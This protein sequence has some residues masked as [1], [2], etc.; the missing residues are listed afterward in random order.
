MQ[1]AW[2]RSGGGQPP[3]CWGEVAT[4]APGKPT[5][6]N[7]TFFHRVRINRRHARIGQG[8][9]PIST[10]MGWASE[11]TSPFRF[12]AEQLTRLELRPP[13]VSFHFGLPE[14]TAVG[15]SKKPAAS[16]QLG[17]HVA[18]PLAEANGESS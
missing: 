1:E 16:S 7:L 2:A 17:D 11:P 10:N 9:H 3:T 5:A 4:V 13:V 12:D 8:L 18:R 14:T 15:G 6:V